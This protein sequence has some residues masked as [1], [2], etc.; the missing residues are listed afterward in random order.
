MNYAQ[1][2]APLKSNNIQPDFLS[3]IYMI[4]ESTPAL[5]KCNTILISGSRL[6]TFLGGA[7]IKFNI[8]A[9][10]ERSDCFLFCFFFTLGLLFSR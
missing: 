8:G 5:Q 10:F 2:S 9:H 1:S 3:A 7:P 4:G 6:G